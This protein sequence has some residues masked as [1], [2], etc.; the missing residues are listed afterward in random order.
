MGCL[1]PTEWCSPLQLELESPLLTDWAAYP[2]LCVAV[3][4]FCREPARYYIYDQSATA[5]LTLMVFLNRAEQL[6]VSGQR[7]SG[8]AA[9]Q[10]FPQQLTV[11]CSTR[12]YPRLVC[13]RTHHV[14]ARWHHQL[15]ERH[16]A[17]LERRSC[18]TKHCSSDL[19]STGCQRQ[20]S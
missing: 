11:R 16:H 1:Q 20:S 17:E 6:S 4:S 3:C 9:P 7:T 12:P 5:P 10:P 13:L 15:L 14:T 8:S 18:N 19:S 2:H